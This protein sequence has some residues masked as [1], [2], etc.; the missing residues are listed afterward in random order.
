VTTTN[1]WFSVDREGLRKLIEHRGKALVLFELIS[2]AWD[3]PGC[4]RV[5]IIASKLP[6]RPFINLIV[7]DDSP[8]GFADL[9]HAYTL[10]AES[11]KKDKPELRGRFNLGEKL[12]L[13]L[14]KNASVKS[15][16]GTVTFNEDGT[17]Q[18]TRARLASG[19]EFHAEIRMNQ[20]EFD[21][22]NAAF[23]QLIPPP[24]ITTIFNTRTLIRPAPVA[25][26][27]VQLPTIV[28]DAEGVLRPTKRNTLVEI[29]EPL[30]GEVASIYELGIP[31]VDTRDKFH[32]NVHQK[33]PLNMDRDNVKPAYLRQLRAAVLNHTAKLLNKEEATDGW[34]TNALEDKSVEPEAVTTVIESRFGKKR[35]IWDP[36]DRE[37]NH[38][39][40]GQ[41]YTVIT[42]G[43]LPRAAWAAVK[44]A[45][46]AQP[47][48]R[49]A[50]SPKPYS[51][52][53]SAPEVEVIPRSEWSEGMKQ[54]EEV[55]RWVAKRLGV[56]SDLLVQ[57][58]K[59]TQKSWSAAYGQGTGLHWNVSCLGKKWFDEWYLHA[60]RFF[61]ILLHELAHSRSMNHLDHDFHRAC[62]GLGA[63][64]VRAMIV[65]DRNAMP[66]AK[67]IRQHTKASQS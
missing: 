8:E 33:V 43:A 11:V 29:F 38:N 2:N 37:A 31:V 63:E 49:I 54:V 22:F 60:T 67:L 58:V 19:S 12:V 14:C 34:V 25:S 50:P 35:A 51:D 3:A 47:A 6:G 41:G 36:T 48:G 5:G 13:S 59:P 39:L 42:G 53:P 57:F 7:A 52:D 55:S 64:L 21:E 15:T 62:T 56:H 45:G 24:G 4:T 16:T 46:A 27:T 28:A 65:M 20:S 18:R 1:N 30:E 10:F 61:D 23:D 66:H 44:A 9:S 17:M 26:F 40:T 32:V